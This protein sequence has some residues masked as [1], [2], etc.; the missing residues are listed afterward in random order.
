M[1]LCEPFE[2]SHLGHYA[3]EL[4]GVK[5]HQE[6]CILTCYITQVSKD[7]MLDRVIPWNIHICMHN[8]EN[9]DPRYLGLHIHLG[10]LGCSKP[11]SGIRA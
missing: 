10:V 6:V 7:C 3:I 9:I 11:I 2:V 5:L 1:M 4:H 8:S